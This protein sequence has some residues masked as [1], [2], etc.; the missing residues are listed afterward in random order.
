MELCVIR[1]IYLSCRLPINH[2]PR[3]TS[4]RLLGRILFDVLDWCRSCKR[5]FSI[6]RHAHEI[7]YPH[8]HERAAGWHSGIARKEE[9][10]GEAIKRIGPQRNPC[11]S[12]GS[13]RLM[14]PD[15]TP[16]ALWVKGSESRSG[17]S[18][19]RTGAAVYLFFSLFFF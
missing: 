18:Q 14:L 19:S 7:T 6:H 2:N 5:R 16:V 4:P 8:V 9:L 17:L 3:E 13:H 15:S 11:Y 12:L 10:I 1:A